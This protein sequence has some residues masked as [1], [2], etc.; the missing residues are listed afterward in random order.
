[1]PVQGKEKE[2]DQLMAKH[3]EILRKEELVTGRD[4]IIMRA[5]NGAV[6]EVLEWKSKAAIDSAHTNPVVQKMWAD[7]SKVCE[8]IPIGDLNESKNLFSEF[9]PFY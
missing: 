3:L 5:A 7:Y 8:Y 2:L 1:M 6:V 9:T 4:S